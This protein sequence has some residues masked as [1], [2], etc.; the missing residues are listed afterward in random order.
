MTLEAGHVAF[1]PIP[2]VTVSD[3]EGDLI[4]RNVQSI[5]KQR[6]FR[7]RLPLPEEARTAE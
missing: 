6:R 3:D 4:V 2:S 5:L 7:R 1:A